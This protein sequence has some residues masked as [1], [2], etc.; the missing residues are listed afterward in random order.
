VPA[1]AFLQPICVQPAITDTHVPVMPDFV[2]ML[3][4][5][6]NPEFKHNS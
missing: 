5:V 4:I 3:P 6:V 2:P 1:L